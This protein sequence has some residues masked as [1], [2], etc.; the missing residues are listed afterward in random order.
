[1]AGET[2]GSAPYERADAVAADGLC[3][4]CGVCGGMCPRNAIAFG[5]D[6]LPRV[7]D[8]CN[9]CGLCARVC[10]GWEF[11]L[12]REQHAA[13][14]ISGAL[15]AVGAVEKCCLCHATDPD[16]R[17]R[18]SS[19]GFVT[20]A[21]IYLLETGRI[22]GALVAGADD[23]GPLPRARVARTRTEIL[24]AAGSQYCLFP[25]GAVLRE[26]RVARDADGPLAVAAI[27]C[28]AHGLR[29]ASRL[30]PDLARKIAWTFGLF[31]SMNME[32]DVVR[33][34]PRARGLAPRA[35][36]RIDFRAG[37]WPGA[38]RARTPPGGTVELFS[39]E[40][41]EGCQ[42]VSHM[43]W[44]HGQPR[45]LL[46]PD[47]SNAL[48][49]FSV[50][51]PWI[52]DAEG[53]FT[54]GTGGRGVVLCRTPRAAHL[55]EEMR[56]AGAVS[57]AEG[58][59]ADLLPLEGPRCEAQRAQALRR[60][61]RLRR[62]GRPYPRFDLPLPAARAPAPAEL[63][64]DALRRVLRFRPAG[65]LFLALAFSPAGQTVSRWN[66]AR[67]RRAWRRTA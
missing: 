54:A 26:I 41:N 6:G 60:I 24:D 33:A 58:D 19:G 17:T 12:R 29:K 67:K 35:A 44:T 10:P 42:A 3:L 28:Q 30:A 46:C 15:S 47:R 4:R 55:V 49:D 65:A 36:G 14:R 57:C 50:C 7:G 38:V 59:A 66:A 34:L 1:M 61:A 25:W 39:R 31:C 22:A 13:P 64:A 16:V 32:P 51:D 52:R 18:G 37:E 5:A 8:A 62:R 40:A 27:P 21:L 20:R 53:R 23:G 48:A 2:P 43:K 11:P 9:R 63:A 45:C 56:D